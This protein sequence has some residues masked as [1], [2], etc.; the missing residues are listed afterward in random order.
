MSITSYNFEGGSTG[1][2]RTESKAEAPAVGSATASARKPVHV[3]S[4]P[5]ARSQMFMAV[6][7]D[8]SSVNATAARAAVATIASTAGGPASRAAFAKV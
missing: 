8:P 5:I 1:R 2:T 4:P 7:R 6:P 3:K